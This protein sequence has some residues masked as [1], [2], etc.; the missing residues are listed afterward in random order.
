MN[1][2]FA[3]DVSM[4]NVLGGAERVLKEQTIRLAKIG[5]TV[6]VITR[7]LPSHT[8]EY[9]CINKVHEWRYDINPSNSLIFLLS[10][11][12]NCQKLFKHISKDVTFDLI[13]FHQPFSA[14]ALNLMKET[15]NIPK[16]YTCHSLS[17][18]EYRTRNL[19]KG[20]LRKSAVFF[21]SSLRKHIERFSLKKS[22]E[23][24]VLSQFTRDKLV[25]TYS[26]ASEKIIIIPGATDLER[27]HPVQ[28]RNSVRAQ[29]N[30]PEDKFLLFTVRNLVPRMGL[31]NLLSAMTLIKKEIPRCHLLIGGSGE[32]EEKLLSL[33]DEYNL[34]D[35]VV[36]TGFLPEEDVPRYCQMAD[37]FVLPTVAL[38]GFG[39]VT[40][41][42]LAC[43]TPVLGTPIGGTKEILSKFDSSFLFENISPEAIADLIIKKHDYY[44]QA[45]NEY[46]KLREQCRKFAEENYSLEINIKK[47]E[48]EFSQ[49]VA[50]A[51]N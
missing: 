30:I 45:N 5:H 50:S 32:L 1:I 11:I 25:R 48:M 36:L 43:G 37:F 16:V 20:L 14:F 39:L 3:A 40:V 27:F 41:E 9:E 26:I 35:S 42:A 2:L 8:S 51:E 4:H 15:K 21:N 31:E 49:C 47:T 7:R 23:I 24:I 28:D 10:T 22:K 33:I 34:K 38:E 17:F 29:F 18:E 6:C 44:K 19:K 12:K 13:N 46:T